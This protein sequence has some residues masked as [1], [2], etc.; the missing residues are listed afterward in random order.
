MF[1][2]CLPAICKI[3]HF[4]TA[5]NKLVRNTVKNAIVKIPKKTCQFEES[6]TDWKPIDY[7]AV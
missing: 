6:A 5:V 2:M 1:G 4:E 3:D 7:V